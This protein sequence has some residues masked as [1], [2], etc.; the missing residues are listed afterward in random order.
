MVEILMDIRHEYHAN[1]DKFSQNIII[2]QIE[3]LLNYTERYYERQFL[4]RKITNHQVL[5]RLEDILTVCFEG[6][7]LINNGLPTV[8]EVAERQTYPPIT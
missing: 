2:T 4:T 6:G 3:L 5:D 8:Q 7:N 1:L